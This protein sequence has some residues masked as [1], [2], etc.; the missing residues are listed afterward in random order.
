[1]HPNRANK[2]VYVHLN[3]N[4]TSVHSKMR[5]KSI[6]MLNKYLWSKAQCQLLTN[7]FIEEYGGK[8]FGIDLSKWL[9]K[10]EVEEDLNEDIID[11]SRKRT[12]KNEQIRDQSEKGKATKLFKD[13]LEDDDFL[14]DIDEGEEVLSEDE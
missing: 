6:R 9:R 3:K 14:S 7:K 12:T 11:K 1:M 13:D 10:E 5:R 8:N 4:I 2:L